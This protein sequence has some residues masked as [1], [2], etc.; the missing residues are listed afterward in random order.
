MRC[1]WKWLNG[2][3]LWFFVADKQKFRSHF[4]ITNR[5]SIKMQVTD[6]KSRH[7][8]WNSIWSLRCA[9][10]RFEFDRRSFASNVCRF[11]AG[12]Q[13][14]PSV[15]SMNNNNNSSWLTLS[16]CRL[17]VHLMNGDDLCSYTTILYV[18]LL[19]KLCSEANMATDFRCCRIATHTLL[20]SLQ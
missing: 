9:H 19:W 3:G 4:T 1:N 6:R 15:W 17:L 11:T 13:K 14:L 7:C 18:R 12:V 10:N 5:R 2:I 8:Y 20:H 16:L